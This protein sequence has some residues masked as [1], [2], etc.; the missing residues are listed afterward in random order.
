MPAFIATKRLEAFFFWRHN[1]TASTLIG[2]AGGL[3][4]IPAQ[5]LYRSEPLAEGDMLIIAQMLFWKHQCAELIECG[6]DC[7]PFGIAHRAKFN[8]GDAG[9][10]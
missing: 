2:D 10:E 4:A 6:F 7:A 9:A 1:P 3:F 5:H 8:I